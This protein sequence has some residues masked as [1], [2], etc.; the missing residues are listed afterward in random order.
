MYNPFSLE[1]KAILITG[2]S[3]GIGR[4]CAI[5]CSLL[6]ANVIITG[7]NEERLNETFNSL[8]GNG[9]LKMTCDLS[10]DEELDRLIAFTPQLN[11]VVINA[12]IGKLAPVKNIKRIDLENV[13]QMNTVSSIL[14]L[15]KLLKAKKI[16]KDASVV[17]T[18][19]MSA[20][21]ETAT[22]NGIYTA[23]K[24][25]ISSF[26]KVAALELA[27]RNIRVNAVCPGEVNTT[28]ISGNDLMTGDLDSGLSRYP[29]GR[30]GNP[31]DVAW[32]MIYLLS[33]ASSWVTGTNLIVDGGLAIH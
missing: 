27:P 5:E 10:L 1:G 32:A 13:L 2:A 17:F 19:S 12:G 7:R 25:A 9:H 23:S 21:G 30:Y 24:G 28:M 33:N 18:S 14:L 29:L 8:S 16:G 15:Q 11:G 3:S 22:G 26:I 6:G 4:A 31:C 20:L